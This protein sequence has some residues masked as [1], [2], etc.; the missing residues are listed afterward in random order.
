MPRTENAVLG[1]L[2]FTSADYCDFRTHGPHMRIDDLS[3]PSGRFFDRVSASVATVDRCP[4]RGKALPAAG[5]DFASVF[6]VPTEV[7]AGSAEG[8]AAATAVAQPTPS[9]S[10]TQG[11]DSVETTVP[12]ASAPSSPGSPAPP[13][14]KP[15]SDRISTQTRRRTATA[16]GNA[17]PAVDYGFG[18]VSY[19]HLT[20]PTIYSV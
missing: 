1:G 4:G 5:N 19:T 13:T 7:G 16:A 20:L 12:T 14:A 8:P 17:P 2:R 15:S 3:A 10:P 6:V 11:T 18:P 9:R